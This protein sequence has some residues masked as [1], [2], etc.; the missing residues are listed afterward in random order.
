MNRLTFFAALLFAASLTVTSCKKNRPSER[1]AGTYTGHF[2]GIY[3]GN[4]TI[5]NT[6]Y[7]VTVT[8]QDKNNVKITA[9]MINTFDVLVTNNGLN[10]E[11]VSPTE[12]LSDFLYEGET[13][14]LSFTYTVDA[15]NTATYVGTK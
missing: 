3:E 15:Q 7:P 11:W 10:V 9:S 1:I 12:G 5:V 8:A 4:D 14:T 2:E 13:K 6:G